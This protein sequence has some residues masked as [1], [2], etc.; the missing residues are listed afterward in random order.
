MSGGTYM[1][2]V[3]FV[4]RKSTLKSLVRQHLFLGVRK[5]SAH[6][7]LCIRGLEQIEDVNPALIVL[8][9]IQYALEGSKFI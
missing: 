8:H 9:A 5:I 6:S 4:L 3:H 7:L 2:I 1:G